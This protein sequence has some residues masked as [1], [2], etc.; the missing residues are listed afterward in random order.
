MQARVQFLHP[1]H[2]AGSIKIRFISSR[3]PSNIQ[4]LALLLD[5]G[6]Q[7][8][9]GALAVAVHDDPSAGKAYHILGQHL[10]HQLAAGDEGGHAQVQGQ[11]Q[12]QGEGAVRQGLLL[13]PL[14]GG[15]DQGQLGQVHAQLLGDLGGNDLQPPDGKAGTE[16]QHRRDAQLLAYGPEVGARQLG[17]L[18]GHEADVLQSAGGTA[19][20]QHQDVLGDQLLGQLGGEGVVTVGHAGAAHHAGQALDLPGHDEVDE[21]LPAAAQ[22]GL[23]ASLA[24]AGEGVLVAVVR[25]EV[26]GHTAPA[27][28]VGGDDLID[29]PVAVGL[30]G[31]I[32]EGDVLRV[33][34]L[35]HHVQADLLD[36]Q[37]VADG[38]DAGEGAVELGQHRVD[39]AA[40]QHRLGDV[41]VPRVAV[42]NLRVMGAPKL[43]ILA[44]AG[45][46]YQL[47]T[48]G[49]CF[50]CFFFYMLSFSYSFL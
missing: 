42:E 33:G 27:G 18:G 15:E 17:G 3:L 46:A 7:G 10:G 22:E 40:G 30:T 37:L 35:G 31:L 6:L 12:G 20:R 34:L 8:V 36:L 11:P 23:Q 38:L 29:D 21:G 48:F 25:E 5:D 4:G 13:Q 19:G 14:G 45:T 47:K 1:S 50:F 32:V 26:H 2:L 44:Y 39:S 28:L 41:V 24:D 16:V 49:S 43:Q 9:G